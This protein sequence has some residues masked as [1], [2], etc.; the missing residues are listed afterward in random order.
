M[1]EFDGIRER[2][3]GK[4]KMPLAMTILFLG[5]AIVGLV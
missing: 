2:K 1:G 4:S 3:E 5:L